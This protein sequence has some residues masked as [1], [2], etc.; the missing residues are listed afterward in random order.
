MVLDTA[1]LTTS[2]SGLDPHISPEAAY[3]QLGRVAAA[4]KLSEEKR[5]QLKALIASTT[6]PPTFGVLGQARVNV[7]RLNIALDENF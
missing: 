1:L 3:F 2:G 4:R 5:A 6:E 7:L